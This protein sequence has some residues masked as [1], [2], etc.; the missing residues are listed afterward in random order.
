M[1]YITCYVVFFGILE[2]DHE[3]EGGQYG[4][5][6]SD[7]THDVGARVGHLDAAGDVRHRLVVGNVLQLYLLVQQLDA[8]LQMGR[9]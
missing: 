7:E 6:V 1:T 2:C 8:H 5:H 4:G 9:V 3:A